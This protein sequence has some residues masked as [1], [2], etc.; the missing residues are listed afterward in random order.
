MKNKKQNVQEAEWASAHLPV[1]GHD[2]GN[3]IV[4]QGWGGRPGHAIGGATRLGWRVAGHC[5][6]TRRP[7]DIAG[8]CAWPG[9]WGGG[10]GCRDT[11]GR[12]LIG[13]RPGCWVYR[14]I[15]CDTV[16][17]N[18]AIRS[19]MRH[20]TAQ[21]VRDMARRAATRRG[22][23]RDTALRHDLR[24]D[25]ARPRYHASALQDTT[26]HAPRHRAVRAR[27]VHNL[28]QGWVHCALDLVLTQCT[29][30]SHCLG[31]CS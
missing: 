11:N 15:G 31:H 25:R 13:G 24:N 20:N 29:I 19:S 28:G 1:L 22:L 4:T 9:R 5:D 10:G 30:L 14:E 12:I 7:C 8:L 3:C 23:E 16:R 2:T 21:E 6:M 18:A 27:L 26:Q 17:S